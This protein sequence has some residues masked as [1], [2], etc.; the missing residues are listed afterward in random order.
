MEMKGEGRT[1][2]TQRSS[3][4][5]ARRRGEERRD[6]GRREEEEEGAQYP[7]VVNKIASSGWM[8]VHDHQ[9]ALL[10]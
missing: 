1:T 4:P 10:T 8:A 6:E 9:K 7:S 3:S 5:A 2:C